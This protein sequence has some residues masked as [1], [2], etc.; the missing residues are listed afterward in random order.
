MVWNRCKHRYVNQRH[1]KCDLKIQ[2]DVL[3][4]SA[5]PRRQNK[6]MGKEVTGD[7]LVAG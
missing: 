5:C 6:V 7:F 3:K 2:A 1:R 4:E